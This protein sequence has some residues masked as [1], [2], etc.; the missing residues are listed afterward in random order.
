M[1]KLLLFLLLTTIFT[2]NLYAVDM[3]LCYTI[4][5]DS[6]DEYVDNYIHANKNRETKN[7]PDW[8][9]LEDSEDAPQV[10]KY[11]DKQWFREHVYRFI[12]KQ[13]TK[14]NNSKYKDAQPSFN[15]DGFTGV[16]S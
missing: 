1:K 9:G 8:V 6:V 14:G 16:L 7:H 11:T 12:R 4:Q 2:S 5:S 15:T 3:N 13:F 10:A